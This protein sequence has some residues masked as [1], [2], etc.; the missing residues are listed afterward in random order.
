LKT[1]LLIVCFAAFAHLAVL[2]GQPRE[3]QDAYVPRQHGSLT[4][5]RDIA[6][7]IFNHCA[8]CHHPGEASPFALLDYSDVDK[9]AQQIVELTQNGLM[10]PWLPE[11]GFGRFLNDRTLSGEEKGLIKQWV[12]EGQARG[13]PED[14]P[15]VPHWKPDWKLGTP[16]LILTMPDTY[17]LGAAGPD[18]YRNFVIPVSMDRDRYVRA[19]EF[20]PGNF[21]IVHHAFVRVDASGTAHNIDRLDPEPGF[22]GMSLPGEAP[23]GQFL[24]WQPGKVAA[25]QSESLAWILPKKCDLVLQIHMNR[26]GKPEEL[27]SSVGLYFTE[28][29]PALSAMKVGLGSLILDFRPGVSNSV[30]TDSFTLPADVKITA[31]LPHAH[32][33]AKEMQGYAILPD[34]RKEWLLWIKHWDFRWQGDYRYAEPVSLP[35]GTTL[36]LRFTYDNSTNNVANPNQPPK[37]VVYG[38]QSS[39]EMCEL[40]FQVVPNTKPDLAILNAASQEHTRGMFSEYAVYRVK[41]DP[42]D[43]QAHSE[44]GM[45]YMSQQKLA[46]A[47]REFKLAAELNPNLDQPHFEMGV[48]YRF[49]NRMP[50]AR[51][52]LE[53]AL[54]LNPKNGQA[55]GHLG[56]V[57][58]EL[59]KAT[60]AKS[61]FEE[62]LELA[63]D[64][65]L[66][67][68]ALAELAAAV[69][70]K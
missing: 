3:T 69:R 15:P 13:K 57:M 29:P 55:Y 61:C 7:I 63:P 54:R 47:F 30:V 27:K 8:P 36:H 31:V 2:F 10:P 14:L 50:E 46:A 65:A 11:P 59:G 43:G 33:L 4:F 66:I 16:D 53:T 44:L 70:R 38:P 37:R 23:N 22:P 60:E 28:K 1:F 41:S 35:K 12:S 5:N 20:N 34:G 17:T 52:E 68:E 39:D 32:Y 42:R 6:P 58:A 64:D 62:A 19:M 24:T 25:L 48:V 51:R 40:W 18:V 9:H 67:K 21:K 45:A 26:S 49:S 56:F